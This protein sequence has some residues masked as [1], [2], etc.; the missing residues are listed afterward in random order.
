MLCFLLFDTGSY[1]NLWQNQLNEIKY[2]D[3]LLNYYTL[4]S[5]KVTSCYLLDLAVKNRLIEKSS[6]WFSWQIFR[7]HLYHLIQCII[8]FWPHS[9]IFNQVVHRNDYSWPLCLTPLHSIPNYPILTKPVPSDPLI[10]FRPC[11]LLRQTKE[12]TKIKTEKKI[13]K[14]TEMLRSHILTLVSRL[15]ENSS[16]K[17]K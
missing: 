15:R 11:Q 10:P 6:Y 7:I 4:S 1:H 9:V 17:R 13:K 5:M 14:K 3:E 12:R 16:I 2:D 8:F